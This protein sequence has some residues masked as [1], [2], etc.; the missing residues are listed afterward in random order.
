MTGTVSVVLKHGD[1]GE[2]LTWAQGL[3]VGSPPQVFDEAGMG[4]PGRADSGGPAAPGPHAPRQGP[5]FPE[6]AAGRP[7]DCLGASGTSPTS[8]QANASPEVRVLGGGALGA[9]RVWGVP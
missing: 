4:V 8:V 7:Q 9:D 2:G 1:S 5:A 3:R 6:A